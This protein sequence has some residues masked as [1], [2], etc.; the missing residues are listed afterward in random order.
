MVW[1]NTLKKMAILT[2]AFF[3]LIACD[4]DY[5]EIGDGLVDDNNFESLRY[6][7]T[8]LAAHSE[9]IES[10]QSNHLSSYALG[11]YK[12]PKYGKTSANILTQLKLSRVDPSFGDNPELDSVVLVVPY[13]STV[14]SQDYQSKE[15][16]LDSIFGDDPIE[17]SV[18]QSNYYL[19]QY[20]PNDDYDDQA[21][22][23]DDIEKFEQ[24]L[25]DAP[26]FTTASFKPSNKEMV[27]PEA[28]KDSTE[29]DTSKVS[30]GMRIKLSKSRFEELILDN[31][32]SDRLASN[33][34]FQEYFRGLYFKVNPVDD[35]GFYGLLNFRSDG[36]G[37]IMYY[38]NEKEDSEGETTT[39]HQ[40]YLLQFGNQIVNVFDTDYDELPADPNNLY[41]KGGE[42][43]M[44]V[45]DLFTDQQQLDSL[46]ETD[47]LIN[48]ANLT[49]YVNEDEL[50]GNQ[51]N[52]QRVFIYDI[53]NKKVLKD[54]SLDPT[55]N[56]NDV[57]NSRTGHLGRLS[58]T[59]QGQLYYKV[60]IT[61]YVNDIINNDSTNTKLGLV[62]SQNV[63]IDDMAE[64]E[65]DSL[66]TTEIPNSEVLAPQGT[67][68]YGPS[69]TTEDKALQLEIY[70]TKPD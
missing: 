7:Q 31:E 57:L 12:D 29:A 37:I 10:V 32:D 14:K 25:E 59:D 62:V 21:Y 63:N 52:P 2:V 26:L 58:K 35:S 22:Y 28:G 66:G 60:R 45:I 4:N 61:S 41:V 54:Y 42:G 70:Y 56:D 67:V 5:K 3:S 1:K 47:W 15:Y 69:S 23:S 19:R 38:H 46:K 48:E 8:S 65:L 9:K 49:F 64:T 24:N 53:E 36:A 18:Y 51:E 6:N 55:Q 68:F 39:Q 43:S 30:P 33:E 40:R 13:F 20:D 17:L 34:N 27:L 50:P 16:E 44:A 11:V